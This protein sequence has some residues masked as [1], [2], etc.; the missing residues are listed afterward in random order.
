MIVEKPKEKE[1]EVKEE[2]GKEKDP[3]LI[4][5]YK[6]LYPSMGVSFFDSATHDGEFIHA[7]DASNYHYATPEECE[8]CAEL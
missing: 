8:P 6:N 3:K 4:A 1:P 5:E 2:E 7:L